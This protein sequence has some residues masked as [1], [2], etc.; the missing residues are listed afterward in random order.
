VSQNEKKR[1]GGKI[2]LVVGCTKKGGGGGGKHYEKKKKRTSLG[3]GAKK[4]NA[5]I[6]ATWPAIRRL[7]FKEKGNK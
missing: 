5:M 3:K 2:K 4:K 7:K 6:G 1:G